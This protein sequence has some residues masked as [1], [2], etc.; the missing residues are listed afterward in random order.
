MGGHHITAGM[1][2]AMRFV[3]SARPEHSQHHMGVHCTDTGALLAMQS[4]GVGSGSP[5]SEKTHTPV[6]HGTKLRGV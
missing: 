6:M 5:H 4:L 1:L 2:A 3:R